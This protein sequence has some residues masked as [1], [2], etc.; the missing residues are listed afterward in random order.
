MHKEH[1]KDIQTFV[2]GNG[3]QYKVNRFLSADIRE[4]LKKEIKKGK[5]PFLRGGGFSRGHLSHFYFLF[6]FASNGLKI[7]FRHILCLV[8]EKITLSFFHF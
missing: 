8:S 6:F 2:N 3:T 4:G 1:R 7:N 5:F